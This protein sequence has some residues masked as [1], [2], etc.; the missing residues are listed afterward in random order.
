LIEMAM[1]IAIVGSLVALALPTYLGVKQQAQD[2][3][4]QN[5]LHTA[6]TEMNLIYQE[7]HT[8]DISEA[9]LMAA[10]PVLAFARSTL[11]SA[12]GSDRSFSIV[13]F[14]DETSFGAVAMSK[15]GRCYLVNDLNGVRKEMYRRP[16]GDAACTL[17][18]S[19]S[20]P[21]AEWTRIR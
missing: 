7:L 12:A 19:L 11:G 8:Y 6:E 18:A 14:G 1:V 9:R 5:S 2:R 20:L 3:V 21:G 4:A 10:E 17:P 13:Y 15:G 16:I